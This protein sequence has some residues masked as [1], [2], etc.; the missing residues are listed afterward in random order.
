M[1]EPLV[2]V[3]IPVYN[4]ARYVRQ[5][6]DSLLSEGWPNLE[7]L[8]VDDGSTDN[9]FEMVQAWR[10]QHPT[11][12]KRFILERQD[13]KGLSRTLN[14]LVRKAEGDFLTPV[15]SDDYLLPNGIARRIEYLTNNP[16]KLAVFGDSIVVDSCGRQTGR[17]ALTQIYKLS[18][19][20]EALKV[21]RL[22]ALELILRWSVPGPGLLLRRTAF[23][24]TLGVGC[25]NESVMIEDRDYYLRLL[26]RGA[27]GFID[28]PVAAYRRHQENTVNANGAK[29]VRQYADLASIAQRLSHQ[30]TGIE[31][32]ALWVEAKKQATAFSGF[33]LTRLPAWFF[34]RLVWALLLLIQDARVFFYRFAGGVD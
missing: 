19:R 30:F 14:Y 6:L 21:S 31:K 3:L 8:V 23:D 26:T 16:E 15:A 10:T 4:H 25:Y 12:F 1:A 5:C 18:A 32:L 13:N 34:W 7:V 24:D 33:E 27:L 17:S 22:M 28:I 29:R 2:S 9:S 20:P 11:A